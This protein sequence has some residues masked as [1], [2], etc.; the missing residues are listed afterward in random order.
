MAGRLG[1]ND[2]AFRTKWRIAVKL[3]GQAAAAG[4]V[5]RAMVAD[6][7]YGDLDDF[8]GELRRAGMGWVVAV[9]PKRGTWAYGPD[10][11]IPRDAAGR[12]RWRGPEE[13]GDWQPVQRRFRD[14]H[15][16]TWWTAEA[17][18]GFRGPDGLTRLVI[19]TTDPV[20]LPDKATWY[21]ATSLPRPG[22]PHDCAC[23]G[24][25][26]HPSRWPPPSW[27]SRSPG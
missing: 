9:R 13:P 16:E 27:P 5:F 2:P 18:L 25:R 3:A 12:L 7:A 10:A 14:R 26:A 22:G 20:T 8:R 15:T 11:H 23:G 1:K 4:V 24:D 21:L 6:C 19:V 17:S